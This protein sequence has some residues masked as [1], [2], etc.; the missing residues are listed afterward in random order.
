MG[1]TTTTFSSKSEN[2]SMNA[3]VIEAWICNAG[4]NEY[5]DINAPK[6]GPVLTLIVTNDPWFQNPWTR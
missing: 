2:A 3:S 6:S 4:R 5:K 1:S